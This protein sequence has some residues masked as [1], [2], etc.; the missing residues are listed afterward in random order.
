MRAL[1]TDFHKISYFQ[2]PQL[3]VKGVYIGGEKEIP[4]KHESGELKTVFTKA[5]VEINMNAGVVTES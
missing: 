5:E 2:V 3:F 1:Y 4:R